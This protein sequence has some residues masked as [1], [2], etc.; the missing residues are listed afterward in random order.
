MA[1]TLTNVLIHFVFSTKERAP[2]ITSGLAPDLHRYIEGIIHNERGEPLAVGGMPDHVHI[3]AKMRADQS[4]SDF[5]RL[6]KTNSSRW[7]GERVTGFAWQTGY[8]AFSVSE[9][10]SE[11]VR[12]YIQRQE[13]HHQVSSFQ[14]EYRA[15]LSRHNV[16]YDEAYVW[17]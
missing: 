9:S 13:K 7:A 12:G 5:V 3:L 15:F 16:A 14:E 4:I 6:V 11:V 10:Q 1:S 17:G 8:G 2:L